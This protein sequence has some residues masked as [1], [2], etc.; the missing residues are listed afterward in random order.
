MN[1]FRRSITLPVVGLRSDALTDVGALKSPGNLP[2]V[3]G[4]FS[5]SYIPQ[6]MGDPLC[7]VAVSG[8]KLQPSELDEFSLQ[9]FCV[10]VSTSSN[11]R[12]SH[13]IYFITADIGKQFVLANVLELFPFLVQELGAGPLVDKQEFLEYGRWFSFP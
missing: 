12:P 8:K 11:L 5:A 9:A 7:I 1:A 6:L 4:P 2:P 13:H 10:L 3:L